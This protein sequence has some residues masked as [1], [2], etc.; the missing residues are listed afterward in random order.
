MMYYGG[1]WIGWTFMSIFWLV[2]LILMIWI[3]VRLMSTNRTGR[4]STSDAALDILKQRY[5]R[6]EINSEEFQRM[7]RDLS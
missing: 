7:K 6:G 3:L 5:A 1:G 2:L 4:D